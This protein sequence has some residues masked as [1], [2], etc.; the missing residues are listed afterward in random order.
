MP[1]NDTSGVTPQDDSQDQPATG[2][3]ASSGAVPRT[4]SNK[5]SKVM[6]AHNLGEILDWQRAQTQ[7]LLFHGGDS[8]KNR[9]TLRHKIGLDDPNSF[10]GRTGTYQDAPH[11]L[12]GLVDMGLDTATDPVT[13]E[14]AGM[15]PL[16]K[17]ARGVG[18]LLSPLGA[19]VPQ[20]VKSLA[21]AGTR[22]VQDATRYGSKAIRAHGQDATDRA[23]AL[24]ARQSARQPVL[25]QRLT[26]ADEKIVAPLSD[27]EKTQVQKILHGEL[28]PATVAPHVRKAA[29]ER[30]TLSRATFALKADKSGQARIGSWGTRSAGPVKRVIDQRVPAKPQ[31]IQE[32]V[33]YL[34]NESDE[35]LRSRRG[36]S[37]GKALTDLGIPIAAPQARKTLR[38]VAQTPY[39]PFELPADL[40]EFAGAPGT[41]S[42]RQFRRNYFPGPRDAAEVSK[43]R[44][45]RE[46]NILDALDPHEL[47]QGDFKIGPKDV[48]NMEDAYRGM[49]SSTARTV[50]TNETRQSLKKIFGENIPTEIRDIF[51]KK[52]A[53]T[54]TERTDLQQV[55][56]AWKKLVNLP[57]TGVVGTS[58]RHM[59]NIA[60][61]LATHAPQLLPEA[62]STFTKLSRIKDPN[63][64]FEFLKEA[65]DMGLEA[66]FADKQDAM[67]GIL[68]RFGAPGKLIAGGMQKMNKATWDFD[69]AAAVTLAKHLKKVEGLDPLV[70]GQRAR[71]ALVDYR[72]TSPMTNALKYVLPFATFK[73]QLPTAV[74]KGVL[75]NAA[76]SE[77]INRATQGVFLGGGAQQG[78]GKK[79]VRYSGPTGE[80][81]RAMLDP[82][83]FARDAASDA[84]TGPLEA[85][86][87]KADKTH[88]LTHGEPPDWRF[89]LNALSAP[90]PY[91][92][93]ILNQLGLG[94]YK[95]EDLWR[96]L[97][98]SSS[99]V[100]VP[101]QP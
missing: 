72:H 17:G 64:R 98:R 74:G 30:S 2:W 33:D 27:V 37:T 79:P 90:A 12:Q 62:V 11:W 7:D 40:R 26:T 88:W 49:L 41:Y 76:R 20:E 57:K 19:L 29:Q 86:L 3:R 92:H 93:D 63:Q 77:T 73:S 4:R 15:G 91:G 6:P 70:A 5:K 51:N 94:K 9:A 13:Y 97:M 24:E 56:E 21:G 68:K 52:V 81:G 80:V 78:G 39:K 28:D 100:N 31:S 1:W 42:N 14:T 48:G 55:G 10:L 75:R 58:P 96:M 16:I 22:L 50:T 60:D 32:F 101:G 44:P 53:A 66:P 36:P 45:A 18:R 84:M 35:F 67:A 59:A 95:K 65:I 46:F 54:G 87:S 85:L 47:H 38:L 83:G 71:R 82:A 34:R 99:G 8:D 61:L 69:V 89:V 23:I 43:N 25:A